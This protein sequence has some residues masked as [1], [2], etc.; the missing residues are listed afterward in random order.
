LDIHYDLG[1]GH[2]LVGRR[3]PD[4]DLTTIKGPR[5][6]F[7]LLYSARP[8]LLNLGESGAFDIAP[9]AGRVQLVDA[10]YAGAWELPVIGQVPSPAAVLIRPDGYVAWVGDSAGRGLVDALTAWFG[11]ATDSRHRK[12][13]GSKL[14]SL[15]ARTSRR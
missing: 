9:W 12:R 7:A 5:R 1:T 11:P 2:P 3:M 8:V 14:S 6:T 4:L 13:T 15:D 10:T